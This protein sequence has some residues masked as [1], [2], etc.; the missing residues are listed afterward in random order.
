M[1]ACMHGGAARASTPGSMLGRG[2]RTARLSPHAS[3]PTQQLEAL[4]GPRR[5]PPAP[6]ARPP[7]APPR[8]PA[9]PRP[10]A[11][12][13]HLPADAVV[14]APRG[15]VVDE[16]VAHPQARAHALRDLG[17]A[18]GR[19]R[20]C[21]AEVSAR[22]SGGS[23]LAPDHVWSGSQVRISVCHWAPSPPPP[24]RRPPQCRPRPRARPPRPPRPR[25][26]CR[27]GGAQRV[28]AAVRGA[29]ITADA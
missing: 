23:C 3:P 7:P 22:R 13:T 8:L 19:G 17:S 14:E 10:P 11:T 16:A 15:V 12:A 20:A 4:R 9:R 26:P 2:P 5:P 1:R 24:A 6:R 25:R 29:L 21:A 27:C 28:G 18:G